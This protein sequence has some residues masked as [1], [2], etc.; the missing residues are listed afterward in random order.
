[1]PWKRLKLLPLCPQVFCWS[2]PLVLRHTV[3]YNVL[4]QIHP[5]ACH[6]VIFILGRPVHFVCAF[7]FAPQNLIVH[8]DS[9]GKPDAKAL[10]VVVRRSYCSLDALYL[11]QDSRIIKLAIRHR[12]FYNMTPE[13]RIIIV[14][15][16][17]SDGIYPNF[18]FLHDQSCVSQKSLAECLCFWRFYRFL[19]RQTCISQTTSRKGDS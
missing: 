5:T 3:Y 7:Y 12:Q 17:Q 10:D 16:Q 13:P 19:L 15:G 9:L 8:F 14:G 18:V 2:E 1:M 6:P 4:A 11:S